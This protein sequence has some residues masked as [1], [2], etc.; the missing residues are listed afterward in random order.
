MKISAISRLARKKFARKVPTKRAHEKHMLEAEESSAKLHFASNSRH[1]PFCR[2]V[3]FQGTRETL[4]LED[5]KCDFLS[6]TH[7]RYTFITHKSK[8]GFL[9]RKP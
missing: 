6:F 3:I 8:G 9:E 2:Y 7:T 4:C 1:R 5:F